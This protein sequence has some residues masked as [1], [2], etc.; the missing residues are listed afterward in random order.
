[1][2]WT[3][4][5]FVPRPGEHMFRSH[6]PWLVAACLTT[7]TFSL[8]AAAQDP[9]SPRVRISNLPNAPFKVFWIC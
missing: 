9:S 3:N 7:L 8:P 6:A 5:P 2:L 4:D 1:M